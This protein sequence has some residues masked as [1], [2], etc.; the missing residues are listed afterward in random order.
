MQMRTSGGSS[1]T[2]VNEFTV[3]PM[4]APSASRVVTTVTPVGKRAM[5]ERKLAPA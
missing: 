4:G 3:S 2:D 1:D 5:T